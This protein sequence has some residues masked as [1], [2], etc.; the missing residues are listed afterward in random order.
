VA[1]GL[2]AEGF[3]SDQRFVEALIH[4]RRQRGYGPLYI[5]RELESK[6]IAPELIAK[7]IR[8][9]APDWLDDLRRVQ[10]KK[11][12]GRLPS[13]LAER[14]KQS[15]FFQSRGFTIDQIRHVLRSSDD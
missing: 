8:A 14:A 1:N 11:F 2:V 13:S 6:G 7:W 15:R 9:R 3:V 4:A 12:G 5:R 10:R